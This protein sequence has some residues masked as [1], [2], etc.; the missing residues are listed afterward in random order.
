MQQ[1][2][3]AAAADADAAGKLV[4]LIANDA[5]AEMMTLAMPQ[6][7][8]GRGPPLAWWSRSSGMR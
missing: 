7:D 4:G 2:S 8:R 6:K 1:N 3:A 5:I